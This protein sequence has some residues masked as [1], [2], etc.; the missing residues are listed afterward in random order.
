MTVA[1]SKK[2]V[3]NYKNS[4]NKKMFKVSSIVSMLVFDICLSSMLPKTRKTWVLI[5]NER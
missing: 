4:S 5:L 3:L 2:N 1:R